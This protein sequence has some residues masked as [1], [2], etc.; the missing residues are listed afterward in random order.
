MSEGFKSRKKEALGT[1][2]H[3]AA[4]GGYA[5]GLGDQKY[6]AEIADALA[7]TLGAAKTR[8]SRMKAA[9]QVRQ[10]R[11]GGPPQ[12]PAASTAVGRR[13]DRR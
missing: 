6:Q 9:G 10:V 13:P 2:Q 1:A 11:S 5:G 3:A 8:V 4:A 7:I 12:I